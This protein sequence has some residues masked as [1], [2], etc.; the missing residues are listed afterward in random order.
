MNIHLV[1]MGAPVPYLMETTTESPPPPLPEGVP[2][3][4]A[5]PHLLPGVQVQA[6]PLHPA[7]VHPRPARGRHRPK[8][9]HIIP[10]DK[11]I[12]QNIQQSIQIVALIQARMAPRPPSPPAPPPAPRVDP[13]YRPLLKKWMT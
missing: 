5:A 8:L 7:G 1:P 6:P 9:T 4:H 3:F 12:I 2:R 11:A 10:R 13:P